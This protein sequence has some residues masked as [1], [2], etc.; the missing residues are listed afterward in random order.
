[1]SFSS[2]AGATG[3]GTVAGRV[4]ASAP[5]PRYPGTTRTNPTTSIAIR[6]PLILPPPAPASRGFALG[7]PCDA[8]RFARRG[9]GQCGGGRGGIGPDERLILRLQHHH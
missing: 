5:A 4:V 8:A 1:M 2:P 7:R 6:M 3:N 9:R